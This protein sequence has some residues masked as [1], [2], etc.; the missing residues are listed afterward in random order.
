MPFQPRDF[1]RLVTNPE[2]VGVVTE[3][4]CRERSGVRQCQIQFTDGAVTWIR[5][6]LIELVPKAEDSVRD[7]REGRL[8]GPDSLRRILLHDKLSGRLAGVLYSMEATET[9]FLPYQF[10]PVLKLIESPCNGLLVADEVGLGKT[11]EAG[12]IWTELRVRAGAQRLLVVCPAKLKIKWVRELSRRFGV[13]A[14]EAGAAEVLQHFEEYR[15]N[16]SHGFALISSYQALRPPSGWEDIDPKTDAR[17]ALAHFLHDNAQSEPVLDLLVMDEA[18]YMRN[19]ETKT[20]ALGQL[21]TDIAGHRV[22]LSATPLHT[23]NRNLYSLLRLL[24]PDTFDTEA[25]FKGILDANAPLVRLRETLARPDSTVVEA[26]D[27]VLAAASNPYLGGSEMLSNLRKALSEV[28]ALDSPSK[29]VALAYQ[30]ERINLLGHAFSRTRKRDVFT[31]EERVVRNVASRKVAMT[32]QER[33]VYDTVCDLAVEFADMHALPS[34]FLD[35]TPQRLVSSSVVAALEHWTKQ[36]ARRISDDADDAPDYRPMV[37]FFRGRLTGRFDLERLERWDTKFYLLLE[38]LKGYWEVHPG[39]KVILFTTFHPTVDY[40]SRRLQAVGIAAF[41]IKG[42]AKIPAQEVI[43]QFEKPDAPLV[44]LS[45]EVGGEGLDMQ[46]A[47]AVINYDLPWNPMV[48]EQRIGRIDRIGQEERQIL[49]LNLLQEGTIDE[50]INDRLYVRLDLFRNSIGDLEAVVGPILDKMQRA[51]LSHRLSPEQ[52]AQVIREAELAIAAEQQERERLEERAAVLAAYGD[53][54]LNQIRAKHDQEQWVTSEEIEHYICDYFYNHAPACQLKGRDPQQR[55]YEIQLDLETH[56][57]MDRFLELNNLRG[58]TGICSASARRIR[59]DHR[60]FAKASGGVELVSQS[61]PLVR[62][63]SDQVRQKRLASCVPVAI[64]VPTPE[65][66]TIASGV[67]F[68]NLQRWTVTG[69]RQ[70]ERLRYDATTL[71]GEMLDESRAESLIEHASRSGERW[72]DWQVEVPSSP[73]LEALEALDDVAS[74]AFI[75]YESRCTSENND[76]ARVQLTSLERFESR[77][78]NVLTG[79]VERYDREGKRNLK[80]A[81]EGQLAKLRE[82][83]AIQRSKIQQ[84]AAIQAEYTRL[85]FGLMRVE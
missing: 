51:L 56:V 29:R 81:T 35:V 20:F 66:G 80:A 64:R 13:R 50:R 25:A 57:E 55:I 76:R 6:E 10:K 30:A 62:F 75:H 52:Q 68:F 18:H 31:K 22:F 70:I 26:L 63:V 67:Y 27:H 1:V 43:Q 14:E 2:R 72:L 82:R 34:G 84:K 49:V 5:A 85:C 37:D 3:A 36:S 17:T 69:L 23:S 47:S 33:D 58:Q 74:D 9:R 42:G 21:T 54:L 19:S 11:I 28:G 44:L 39:K 45:T 38:E 83:C 32:A 8:R 60:V 40:L 16:G 24:D 59:F 48:V 71:S 65:S 77:R 12:L 61:H 73:A 4:G 53:Y 46:F 15:R 79:L 78:T 7:F 41:T